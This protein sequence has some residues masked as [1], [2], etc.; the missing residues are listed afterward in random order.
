[1]SDQVTDLTEEEKQALS[2]I[3]Q[4]SIGERQKT[5]TGRL[6][7]VYKIWISGKAKMTPDETIDSLVKRGLVS[8]SETNWICITEEGK[9]LVKKI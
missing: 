2:L 6:Q 5:I 3:A 7:K 1:M 4:F 9:K 8:R